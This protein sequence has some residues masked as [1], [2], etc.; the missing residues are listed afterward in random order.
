[1]SI[2]TRER[3]CQE[4]FCDLCGQ[5]VTERQIF[6]FHEDEWDTMCSECYDDE[7][8]DLEIT[9]RECSDYNAEN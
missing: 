5:I 2:E 7:C 4:T 3:E 6:N 9:D 8:Y 1:M